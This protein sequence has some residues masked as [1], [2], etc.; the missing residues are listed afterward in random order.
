MS[1][2]RLVL[3]FAAGWAAVGFDFSSEGPED[4]LRASVVCI[5]GGAEAESYP[6]LDMAVS[7]RL[8]FLRRRVADGACAGGSGA[9]TLARLGRFA[10]EGRAGSGSSSW[11]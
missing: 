2:L 3:R 7:A 10:V 5:V 4:G 9:S 8:A 6:A 11:D 1:F